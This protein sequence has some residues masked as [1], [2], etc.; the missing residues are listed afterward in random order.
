MHGGLRATLALAAPSG[1]LTGSF[2]RLVVAG[3]AGRDEAGVRHHIAELAALGVRPPR[4]VPRSSLG[5]ERCHPRLG[6]PAPADG[7]GGFRRSG[8]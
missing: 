1:P 3:W 7:G 6:G 5:R 2:E 4:E 8:G